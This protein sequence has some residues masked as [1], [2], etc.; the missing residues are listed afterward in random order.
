MFGVK[1]RQVR[2]EPSAMPSGENTAGTELPWQQQLLDSVW[3]LALAAL[4]FFTLS[5]IVLGLIDLM[6]IPM[7]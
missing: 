5:Y 1:L 7:G 6:T 4:L 3:L 2:A